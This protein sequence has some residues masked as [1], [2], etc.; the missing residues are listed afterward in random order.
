MKT[1]A[2]ANAIFKPRLR[3]CTPSVSAGTNLNTTSSRA[4]IVFPP[5]SLH[6]T[7]YTIPR[8]PNPPYSGLRALPD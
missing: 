5:P 7:T 1:E 3:R 4:L 6:A 8:R 2:E